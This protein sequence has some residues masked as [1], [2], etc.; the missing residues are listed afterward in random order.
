MLKSLSFNFI[1]LSIC[2]LFLNY[3]TLV[4][5][6]NAIIFLIPLYGAPMLFGKPEKC[7]DFL[8]SFIIVVFAFGSF[9]NPASKMTE[10]YK[11]KLPC[12]GYIDPDFEQKFKFLPEYSEKCTSVLHAGHGRMLLGKHLLKFKGEEYWTNEMF[13]EYKQT[14]QYVFSCRGEKGA[15]IDRIRLNISSLLDEK[16]IEL[17]DGKEIIWFAKRGNILMATSINIWANF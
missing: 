6:N 9:V 15:I 8:L 17:Q 11:A 5:L 16:T 4:F 12:K 3:E 2:F 1:L 13:K 10:D 7:S 14:K